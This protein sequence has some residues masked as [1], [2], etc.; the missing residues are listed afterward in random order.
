[1]AKTLGVKAIFVTGKSY[2]IQ[3]F[4][5]KACADANFQRLQWT[6][7][8]LESEKAMNALLQEISRLR[9]VEQLR[10]MIRKVA[11]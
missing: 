7:P 4:R 10:Q 3:N 8:Y 5:S 2:Q 1:M 11:A 9:S 6:V